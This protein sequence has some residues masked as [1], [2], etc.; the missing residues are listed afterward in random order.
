MSAVSSLGNKVIYIYLGFTFQTFVKQNASIILSLFPKGIEPF[1]LPKNPSNTPSFIYL[2][3]GHKPCRM[4]S[5]L[6]QH[7]PT[8]VQ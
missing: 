3:S 4:I 5:N 7:I 6:F 1:Q 8:Y 2:I